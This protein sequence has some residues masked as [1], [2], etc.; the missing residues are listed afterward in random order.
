MPSQRATVA[1]LAVVGLLLL[2][3]PVWL[4]P[5]A[6]QTTYTY[7]RSE[8]TV[9]NG[10]ITYDGSD[11]PRFF[12]DNDLRAVGCQPTDREGDRAC[13]FDEH[14]VDHPSVTVSRQLITAYSSP[15]YVEIDGDYYRRIQRSNGSSRTHDVTP[16][17]PRTVLRASAVDV[18][19]DPDPD[20]D[21]DPIEYYVAVSGETVTAAERLER[22]DV[23][24]LYRQNGTYYTVVGTGR[25]VHQPFSDFRNWEALRYGLGVVGGLFLL[26][27]GLTEVT[28][29]AA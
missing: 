24:R 28:R 13:A 10:S 29:R 11:D 17:S 18:S 6:G 4:Y 25:T 2:S 12:F 20:R 7:E 27:A 3:N 19:D 14:L 8:V 21:D 26:A 15:D 9:E 22:R 1:L 5:S 16:V 23:G